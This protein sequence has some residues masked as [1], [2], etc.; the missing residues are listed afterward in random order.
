MASAYLTRSTM[1]AAG[2]RKTFTISA[3]WLKRAVIGG[4]HTIFS[5]GIP[6]GGYY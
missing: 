5:Q 3:C 2:N 4:D 1:K 6:G